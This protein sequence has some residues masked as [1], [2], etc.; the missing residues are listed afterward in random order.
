MFSPGL[1]LLFCMDSMQVLLP[2]SPRFCQEPGR[3]AYHL[4]Q[5]LPHPGHWALPP[6]GRGLLAQL[7]R[8]QTA[9]HSSAG[10][11]GQNHGNLTSILTT[12]LETILQLQGYKSFKGEIQR[13]GQWQWRFV[14]FLG[15]HPRHTEAPRLRVRIRAAAAGWH[16]SHSNARSE[17]SRPPTSQLTAMADR[18]PTEQGQW[19]SPCPHGLVGFVSAEPWRELP[20]CLF[21][22]FI[23]KI[24]LSYKRYKEPWASR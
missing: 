20:V 10:A 16:H 22:F 11:T 17:P 21:F 14:F 7:S 8:W 18:W 4:W 19:L 9:D 3:T 23:W 12:Q 5:W 24:Q 6:G 13:K 1:F 15:P 2:S